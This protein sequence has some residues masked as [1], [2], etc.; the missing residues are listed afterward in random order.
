MLQIRTPSP[1]PVYQHIAGQCEER[2]LATQ[3]GQIVL[4]S[5]TAFVESKE[6]GL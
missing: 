4:G 6:L 1:H 3:E 5:L 2:D